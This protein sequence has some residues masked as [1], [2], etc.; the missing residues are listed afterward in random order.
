MGQILT[1]VTQLMITRAVYPQ[2]LAHLCWTILHK[3]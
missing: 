1:G 3:K 2:N